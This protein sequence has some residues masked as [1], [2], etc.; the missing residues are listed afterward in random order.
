MLRIQAVRQLVSETI[1]DLPP[2]LHKGLTSLDVDVRLLGQQVRHHAHVDLRLLLPHEGDGLRSELIEVGL[3]SL[4]ELRA[5]TI[6]CALGAS[7]RIA[8]LARPK[9]VALSA[10]SSLFYQRLPYAEGQWSCSWNSPYP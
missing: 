1:A 6:A 4:K 2:Q 10:V 8:A 5:Q 9:R 7:I 3:Q